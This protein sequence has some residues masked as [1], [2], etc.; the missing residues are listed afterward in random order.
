MKSRIYIIGTAAL[1]FAGCSDNLLLN[2][3]GADPCNKARVVLEATQGL[4][5][6]TRTDIDGTAVVWTDDDAIG[7]FTLASKAPDNFRISGGAGTKKA[8]FE[9]T[10]AAEEGDK[11]CA[12]YPYAEDPYELDIDPT[13]AKIYF[14]PQTQKGF[15][16]DAQKHLGSFDYMAA[17]PVNFTDGKG[18]KTLAFR[19]LAAKM[20]FTFSLPEAVKVR[21][22]TISTT[23]AKLYDQGVV[24]LTSDDPS[25]SKWGTATRTL[26][27]GFDEANVQPGQKAT[28]YMMMLP[29]D[30]SSEKL[31]FYI[32]GELADG[33]PVTY[34]ASKP[35]GARFEAGKRYK[36][37]LPAFTKV[38]TKFDMVYVPGGSLNICALAQ[39]EDADMQAIVDKDYKV[40]SFW[41][42]RTEVTNS[43]FCEFLNDRRPND[44][45]LLAWLSSNGA[46]YF[47]APEWLQI[48]QKGGKWVPKSGKI[49][50]GDGGHTSGS[51]ADYPMIGVT[52][53]GATAYNFYLVEQWLGYPDQGSDS[54]LP[55]ELQ[56][57]YAATGSQWNPGALT[58]I[59]PGGDDMDEVMWHAW[60]CES[61]G[62]CCIKTG[63]PDKQGMLQM[64]EIGG[65]HPVAQKKPNFLGIYDMAGNAGEICSDWYSE[66]AYPYGVSLNPKC[67]DMSA[68]ESFYGEEC[69]SLRGGSWALFPQYGITY[70]RDFIVATYST[71]NSG[72]RALIPLRK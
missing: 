33:T 51:Y 60:N 70:V 2:E 22:F 19:H 68:A 50:D 20:E 24:D 45:Q 64:S 63:L 72:F 15:G 17:P 13:A 8:T 12:L 48:E 55:S 71:D 14:N 3:P 1:V 44:V 47:E 4:N 65:S 10:V 7:I 30:L 54:I 57:E 28:A 66:T 29:H 46:Y 41:I 25:A 69:R 59:F 36:T 16:A 62:S 56:W 43:Q 9:G 67:T 37:E 52:P 21:F 18:D 26:S 40:D 35:K 61:A 23:S 11:L 34:T 39:S 49:Y 27:M 31:T 32:S 42:G 6:E 5:S 58:D 38:D 53:Q